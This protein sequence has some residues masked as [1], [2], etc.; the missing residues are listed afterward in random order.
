MHENA[1]YVEHSGPELNRL[2]IFICDIYGSSFWHAVCHGNLEFNG[3]KRDWPEQHM[4][5]SYHALSLQRGLLGGGI[6]LLN[7]LKW[8]LDYLFSFSFS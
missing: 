6:S 8:Y 3:G 5:F 1:H 4:L 7:I 2:I